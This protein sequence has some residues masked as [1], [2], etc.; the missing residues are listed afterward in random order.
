MRPVYRLEDIETFSITKE[1]REFIMKQQFTKT[2]L[3]KHLQKL[4]SEYFS[5]C[6]PICYLR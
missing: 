3:I 5:K 6:I 4:K 2:Q 1:Q